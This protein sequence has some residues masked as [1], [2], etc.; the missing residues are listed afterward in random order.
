VAESV[1]ED[2]ARLESEVEAL[3]HPQGVLYHHTN[4]Q[5]LLGILDKGQIWASH[6]R[7]LNDTKEY[8]AGRS[9]IERIASVM[10]EL[11]YADE[12]TA[13][14]V[15]ITLKII[16][17]FDIYVTSFSRADDGD[18]LNLWRAYAQTLPGFSIGFDAE[19]LSASLRPAKDGGQMVRAEI[20]GLFGVQY[21]P[22]LSDS[23]RIKREIM[24]LA[25]LVRSIILE[26]KKANFDP[27]M[28][29]GLSAE[30]I[31]SEIKIS[32]AG[33]AKSTAFLAVL[34][35][36]LKHEGFSG[37]QEIR[38]VE[39][40]AKDDGFEH[41]PDIGFHP[42]QSSIVPHLAVDLPRVDL[43]IR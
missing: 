36:L 2:E 8:F 28:M 7:Y 20:R 27:S 6:I 23:F 12:E 17:T 10:K 41:C 14:T 21:V 18:S 29:K 40:R 42:G 4:Q 35:P 13:R 34:L 31:A 39:L 25:Q 5:G 38:L 19:S 26:L 30:S 22:E 37:E 16:D 15:D 11:N 24:W 32:M 1:D 43:G 33:Y 3:L 9:F